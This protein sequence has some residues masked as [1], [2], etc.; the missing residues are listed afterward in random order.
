MSVAMVS[1]SGPVDA[2][3]TVALDEACNN[4]GAIDF[5]NYNGVIYVFR[6]LHDGQGGL[7]GEW[8]ERKTHIR[9]P[10]IHA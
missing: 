4:L 7:R 3:D 5:W 8:S 1:T 9:I 2:V 6:C 10:D